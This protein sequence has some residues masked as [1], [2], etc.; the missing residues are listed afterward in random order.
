MSSYYLVNAEGTVVKDYDGATNVPV[1]TI[2]G[3]MKALIKE[4]K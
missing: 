3:D 1:E 4:S 2:V